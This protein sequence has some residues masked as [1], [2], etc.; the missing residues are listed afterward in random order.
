[1]LGQNKV[2]DYTQDRN[3]TNINKQGPIATWRRKKKYV[4]NRRIYRRRKTDKQSL[5]K[6]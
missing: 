6:T 4:N 3:N 1:M 2:V 5:G